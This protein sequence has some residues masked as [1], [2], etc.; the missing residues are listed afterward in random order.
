MEEV[1]SERLLDAGRT[2]RAR[3]RQ[4]FISCRYEMTWTG[5][6]KGYRRGAN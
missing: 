2:E 1:P 4:A 6:A 3:Y 5:A